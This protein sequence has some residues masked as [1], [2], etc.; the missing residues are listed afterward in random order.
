MQTLVLET[1][2]IFVWKEAA[3]PKLEPGE[4]LVRVRRCGVCGT[5]IHAFA[6]RQPFFTYPRRLGH[7]LAVEVLD[8]PPDAVVKPG[9]LCAVEPY[10]FCGSCVACRMGK[11]NCCRSLQLI[12]VHI[13]GG[14]AP[15]IAVPADKLHANTALSLE[16]LALVEP[17]VIGAHAVERAALVPDEPV[18]VVGMGPIGLSVALYARVA[19]VDL[20]VVD[21]N[22]DR[23]DFAAQLLGSAHPILA[24]D[25][26]AERLRSVFGGDLPR[27]VFDVT[28]S[29]H[30]MRASFDLPDHGGRLIFVGLIKGDFAFPDPDFHRRELTILSSRNGRPDNFRHVIASLEDG[31]VD[32]R[33]LI[34]HRYAFAEMPVRFPTLHQ[35]PDLIK[36]MITIAD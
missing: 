34:T 29:P 33:P 25:S 28:G 31:T 22:E 12:G 15:L 23:L 2:G 30:A 8:A 20:A 4:V 7:E 35:T 1:P 26:L 24:G 5:D 14:H 18:A 11:T 32:A 27:A 17:L 19:G 13:D 16:E 9:D 10:Y 6:G 36:A 21:I 3:E